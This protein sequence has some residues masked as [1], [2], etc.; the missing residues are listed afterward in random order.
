MTSRV[1]YLYVMSK[2]QRH[3]LGNMLTSKASYSPLIVDERTPKIFEWDAI[4]D[5]VCTSGQTLIARINV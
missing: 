4:I 3:K 2:Q 5:A 1:I